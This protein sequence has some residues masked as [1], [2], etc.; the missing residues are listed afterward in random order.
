MTLVSLSLW[1]PDQKAN[2]GMAFMQ[3]GPPKGYIEAV[4][5]RLEKLERI[6]EDIAKDKNDPRLIAELNAPLETPTGE[7]I[8]SRPVRRHQR[9]DG[10]KKRRLGGGAD[11]G[12]SR[13]SPMSLSQICFADSPPSGHLSY[14]DSMPSSP[15]SAE[16]STGQL[17]MDENGQVRYLGKSSGYYLLQGSRTYQNG[18]FHFTGYNHKVTSKKKPTDLDPLELPPKDLSE[19]L[20]KLY[21]ENF[22]PFLPLF[23]KRRLTSSMDSALE[24]VSPLLLNAIYAVAS[25]ISPDVRVRSDPASADTAGDIFVERAKYLLDS[26][27]DI[28]RIST[29]QALLLLASHQHGTMNFVRG[30]MYSGMVSKLM[31]A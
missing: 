24:P 15:D 14:P 17:S 20:L 18:A 9:T 19:H 29:V 10:L 16:D 22:Y 12:R 4:E 27:Y 3:R 8:K 5:N 28:P 23:Y 25:R 11:E 30:W 26:Y 31:Q 13:Q 6:L 1:L 21:F 2:Q 7:I